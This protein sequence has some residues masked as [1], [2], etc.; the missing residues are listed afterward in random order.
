[1]LF[2]AVFFFS[3]SLYF[4]VVAR[5]VPQVTLCSPQLEIE[6]CF[7]IIGAHF[8]NKTTMK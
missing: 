3:L 8:T 4:F 1:M 6:F 7:S 5:N 2:G